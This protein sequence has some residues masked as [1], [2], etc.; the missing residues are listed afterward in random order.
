[1]TEN[2]KLKVFLCH[3]KDDK[4]K[5]RKLYKRLLTDGFDVWL[6]EEKLM[7]GQDWDLEI[8][9][10]VRNADTVIVCISKDSTTKEGYIQKEIGFALDIA[11]EKPEGTIFLIP[12][13]L[14]DCEVPNR[15]SRYQ[16][17]D[18]FSRNNYQKLIES[19]NLRMNDLK[20]RHQNDETI[21]KIG[22]NYFKIPVAGIISSDGPMPNAVN[23][24]SGIK[25]DVVEIP[26]T[27]LP[28]G[29][30]R[31]QLFA[32]QVANGGMLDAM[33]ND[34]DIVIMKP[35]D[36]AKN[37]EMVAMWLSDRNETILRYYYK[38]KEGYRLQSADPTYKPILIAK[39]EKIEVKGKVVMLIRKE[40]RYK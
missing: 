22:N 8:R 11:D 39:A 10:A 1:M 30:D 15:I 29:E 33:I 5:V 37:G 9:K 7:P 21:Y 23:R 38:E 34:G 17:F 32:L 35:T 16:W 27:L 13:R 25:Y 6:D 20:I 18:L 26:Q 14:E 24:N 12:V 31:L 40:D 3:S 2:R 28:K 19:L 36:K 4:P